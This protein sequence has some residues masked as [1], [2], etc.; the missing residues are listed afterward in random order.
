LGIWENGG[1]VSGYGIFFGEVME[2]G[3]ENF[4]WRREW[5]EWG[6]RVV[7]DF[8][9]VLEGANVGNEG[10]DHWIWLVDTSNSY[11][12]NLAYKALYGSSFDSSKVDFLRLC[13][14]LKFPQRCHFCCGEYS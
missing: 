6:N 11:T 2:S 7:E 4:F 9:R 12:V 3:Y 1:M 8:L 5:F 14:K 13:D 10:E